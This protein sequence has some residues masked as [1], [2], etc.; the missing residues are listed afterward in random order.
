MSQINSLNKAKVETFYQP[1]K[2]ARNY[3]LR[4][5]KKE[6]EKIYIFIIIILA[7]FCEVSPDRKL[8]YN[9]FNAYTD[10]LGAG[11]WPA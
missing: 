9:F 10:P 2:S 8:E 11:S 4:K 6:E 5:E 1:N 3:Q 7:Q